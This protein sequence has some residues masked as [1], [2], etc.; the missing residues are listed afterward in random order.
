MVKKRQLTLTQAKMPTLTPLPTPILKHSSA[1]ASETYKKRKTRK[2]RATS[3][4]TSNN[5]VFATSAK[6]TAPN[7]SAIIKFKKEITTLFFELLLMVKLY[8]WNTHSYANHKATDDLYGK[9]ND[10]I[11][12]FM[13]VL[14]G[15]TADSGRISLN[16]STPIDLINFDEPHE[17]TL[18]L[19]QYKAYLDKLPSNPGFKATGENNADL[20][21]IRDEL[22]ADINQFLYLFTLHGGGQ[23][24]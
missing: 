1:S 18:K 15:K 8:H 17:L 21:T 5:V 12:H 4:P 7:A 6:K 9:L 3:T 16:S 20:L 10:N 11:D 13:E 19:N 24:L 14:L 2:R 22:L 23:N